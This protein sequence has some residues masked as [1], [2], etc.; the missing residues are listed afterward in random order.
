MTLVFGLVS[1]HP[2]IILPEVGGDDLPK[3]QKTIR[4]LEGAVKALAVAKPEKLIV[5]APHEGHGFE[6]PEYF[7]QA[8]LPGDMPV[9]EVLVTEDSYQYYFDYG[10]EVG[11]RMRGEKARCAIV[12]SGDLSHVLKADG[13][14][15]FDPA[16]P[17]L[18]ELI[19]EG[20]RRGDAA[21]LLEIDPGTLENGAECGLRSILFL[22]GAMDGTNLKAEVLS[23]EGP[24]G[25]GYMV[26]T[27][28]M[29]G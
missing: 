11:A 14:Y 12:A 5:I 2:P 8:E 20:V 29:K 19:V 6:V 15:G 24:F 28:G 7:L 4:A 17:V 9:E 3:V 1:P 23:Y 21:A 25:V 26:A 16:G 22:L 27:F 10:K 18:D 13:P